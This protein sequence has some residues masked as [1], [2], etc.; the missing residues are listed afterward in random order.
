MSIPKPLGKELLLVLSSTMLDN[1]FDFVSRSKS[2]RIDRTRISMCPG[3]ELVIWILQPESQK[4]SVDRDEA[5]GSKRDLDC[6]VIGLRHAVEDLV[7]SYK[8]RLEFVK[9]SLFREAGGED[10]DEVSNVVLW[11]RT[12]VFIG[13]LSYGDSTLNKLGLDRI[14]KSIGYHIRSESRGRDD[15]S[16]FELRSKTHAESMRGGIPRSID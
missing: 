8:D 16:F 2:I 10:L 13:L 5:G 7:G 3:G 12:V 14:S 15:D 6:I 1:M 11:R 4:R 9:L